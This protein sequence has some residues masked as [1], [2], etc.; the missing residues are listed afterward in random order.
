M[1]TRETPMCLKRLLATSRGML[2]GR[3]HYP[4]GRRK[5]ARHLLRPTSS[6]IN[7]R[8]YI[9]VYIYIHIMCGL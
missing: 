3:G 9:G 1:E 7:T 4:E 2:T 5:Q 6:D 8:S